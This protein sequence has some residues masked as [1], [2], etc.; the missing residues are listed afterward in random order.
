MPECRRARPRGSAGRPD[1]GALGTFRGRRGHPFPI[2]RPRR[3]HPIRSTKPCPELQPTTRPAMSGAFAAGVHLAPLAPPRFP[4]SRSFVRTAS[5]S[6]RPGEPRRGG[7][8]VPATRSRFTAVPTGR[9]ARKT[10]RPCG[11]EWPNAGAWSSGPTARSATARGSRRPAAAASSC[12]T[13]ATSSPRQSCLGSC[14]DRTASARCGR[15]LKNG[16]QA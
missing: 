5:L 2:P 3:P 8:C 13:L 1:G 15:S 6:A 10:G 14:G 11:T 4:A 16:S 12:S 7:L 9:A